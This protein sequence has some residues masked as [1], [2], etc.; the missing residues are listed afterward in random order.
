[1]D[2]IV[3]PNGL[4]QVK[5][6]CNS[7]MLIRG[8]SNLSKK[9]L[10]YG[11]PVRNLESGPAARTAAEWWGGQCGIDLLQDALACSFASSLL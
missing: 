9:K 4:N 5:S 8:G 3:S 1:M 2:G 11:Q 10:F 6:T 7:V